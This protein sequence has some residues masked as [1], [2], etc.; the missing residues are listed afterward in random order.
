[1]NSNNL[2][3]KSASQIAAENNKFA[4]YG[5]KII[6]ST[7]KSWND[8]KIDWKALIKN[9][10][11][12][13][14]GPGIGFMGGN[15]FTSFPAAVGDVGGW[16]ELA[17]ASSAALP[18]VTSIADKRYYMILNFQESN[19]S[20]PA[21]GM[22]VNADTGTN[23][24]NRRSSNGAADIT[25]V[26]QAEFDFMNNSAG[27]SLTIPYFM[28][29]YFA[30]LSSR[31]KLVQSWGVNSRGGTGAGTEPARMEFTGKWA[32]TADAIDQMTI[33]NPSGGSFNANGELVV[34]GWDPSD[35]HTDNFWE[36]LASVELGSPSSTLD[37]GIF[38]TK[39]YLWI[40]TYINAT[41]SGNQ[42]FRF[43]SD[44]GSNYSFRKSSSGGA[45]TTGVN[46][47]NLL[48]SLNE[49]ARG[50]LWNLFVIN[51]SSIEKLVTG[52]Q[53]NANNAGAGN[54]PFRTEQVMKWNNTVD[55]IDEFNIATG[56]TWGTGSFLK[57][58]GS[59]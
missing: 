26:S 53:N 20:N 51:N 18:D 52:H 19:A 9:L 54:V 7:K 32:N 16:V 15:A 6:D 27:G 21:V 48:G 4:H 37:S 25:T 11:N 24:A 38:S 56:G 58:W 30:N 35:T 10:K 55:L 1:M 44:S 31:E 22:T 2:L 3:Y 47:T 33:I 59:D 49:G 45:D 28:C 50:Q 13:S 39:K 42:T 57:V 36:E 46:L 12:P 5:N 41:A 34:L 17:R 29:G 8:A 43:N 40:Q 23:Y 14:G